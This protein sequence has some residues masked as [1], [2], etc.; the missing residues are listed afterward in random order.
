MNTVI[1]RI[2]T[3]RGYILLSTLRTYTPATVATFGARPMLTT[4]CRISFPALSLSVILHLPETNYA[5]FVVQY[6]RNSSSAPFLSL[7][8]SLSL[9]LPLAL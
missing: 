1:V 6:L 8:L 9:Y 5:N 4:R 7:S 2:K 3:G